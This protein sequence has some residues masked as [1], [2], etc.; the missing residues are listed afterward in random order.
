MQTR[1]EAN[2]YN[3]SKAGNPQNGSHSVF[4]QGFSN[5]ADA[6]QISNMSHL[7]GPMKKKQRT[8]E[9]KTDDKENG[10][11]GSDDASE[12]TETS[13]DKMEDEVFRIIRQ[14]D[15]RQVQ[16]ERNK[17][18]VFGFEQE[19][20]DDENYYESTFERFSKHFR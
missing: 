11:S 13:V 10:G 7:L 6:P 9:Q 12:A 4:G 20:E 19:E 1:K 18:E 16:N 3:T 15:R 14:V 17:V 2:R 5:N 8:D